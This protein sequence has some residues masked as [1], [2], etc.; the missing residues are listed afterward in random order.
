MGSQVRKQLTGC[1]GGWLLYGYECTQSSDYCVHN[2]SVSIYNI[3]SVDNTVSTGS[4]H[5]SN[6]DSLPDCNPITNVSSISLCLGN[7]PCASKNSLI[8][9]VDHTQVIAHDSNTRDA[10]SL[11]HHDSQFMYDNNGDDMCTHVD[12]DATLRPGG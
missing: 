8:S 7:H 6:I 12:N 11:L 3:V 10:P 9:C 2:D 5:I 1:G 4:Y